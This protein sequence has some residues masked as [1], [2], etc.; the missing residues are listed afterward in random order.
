[1]Q[2]VEHRS[3]PFFTIVFYKPALGSRLSPLFE[4]KLSKWAPSSR[5]DWEEEPGLCYSRL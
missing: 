3:K 2:N 1:M 5:G 4:I